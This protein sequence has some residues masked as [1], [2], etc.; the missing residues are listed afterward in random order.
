MD[1]GV[2]SSAHMHDEIGDALLRS[3]HNVIT[4]LR[5]LARLTSTPHGAQRVAW[6]PVWK[7]ARG[8][9]QD[10]I[11]PLGLASVPDAAGNNW[12]TLPGESSRTVI[13]GGHLDSGPNGGW[14]EG[15]P[16]GLVWPE[17]RR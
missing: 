13:I 6:G 17:A 14:R 5:E 16:A 12:V 8:W 7:K 15:T 1:R 10:K 2:E 3:A 9:L 11:S 4:D